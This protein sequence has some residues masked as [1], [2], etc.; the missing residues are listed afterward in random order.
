MVSRSEFEARIHEK[1]LLM[2][3][4]SDRPGNASGISLLPVK[5]DI[6]DDVITY[7][8]VTAQLDREARVVTIVLNG[9]ME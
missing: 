2:A 9:P 8:Y 6:A 1:A 4:S 7:P 3:A 5:R